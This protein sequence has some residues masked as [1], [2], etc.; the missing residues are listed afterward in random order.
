MATQL[1]VDGKTPIRITPNFV[2]APYYYSLGHQQDSVFADLRDGNAAATQVNTMLNRLTPVYDSRL[3]AFYA[4]LI[5]ASASNKYAW[6]VTGAKGT[7]VK[8]YFLNGQR[9][10]ALQ[11]WEDKDRDALT[12]KLKHRVGVTS[13]AIRDS[14]RMR[15]GH[16]PGS[17]L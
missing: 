10:F 11:R 14:T 4:A 9:R 2:I 8:F 1:D 3:D 5:A 17:E 7:S 16:N 13:K 12:I 15:A 6:F